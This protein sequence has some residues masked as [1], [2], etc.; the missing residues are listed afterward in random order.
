VRAAD[1]SLAAVRLVTAD[2]ALLDAA[3]D[4]RPALA[5]ALGCELADG[6]DVF[7][8]SLRR[9]RDALD[10]DP[11]GARWGTRLVVV[12]VP[13]MLVG[14]S[15]FKGPPRDGI[16][17]LGYAIAPSWEGRGLATAAV[18]EL[19]RE[20]FAAPC[21]LT[22][23]AHT[24]AAPGPSPRVLEKAGFIRD[25]DVPH[26]ELGTTWRFRHDRTPG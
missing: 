26:D 23:I 10:A 16:V 20:A 3:V 24:P 5:R 8:T 7:P 11:G 9:I 19:L 17:E 12:D 22:V 14:W 1:R 6:W 4:D 2:R 13:P 21:V 25:G 18:R 15:G